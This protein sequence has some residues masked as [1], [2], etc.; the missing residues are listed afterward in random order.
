MQE[1]IMNYFKDFNDILS[2]VI[3]TN[4]KNEGFNLNEGIENAIDLIMTQTAEENKVVFV[5]NGGSA[6]IS[7]HMA[8]DFWKNGEMK[9]LSFN[10]PAQLTCLSNDYG[11]QYVFEKPIRMFADEGDILVAVSSSGRSENILKAVSA[12]RDKKCKVITMSGFNPDNP[13]R[14]SGDLNF[15]VPSTSYG[16]VEVIHQVLCHCILDMIIEKKAEKLVEEAV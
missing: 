10:D 5:G 15:Y 2:N 16:F 4:V 7:S 6:S 1:D 11:Y 8:I 12:S 13:L 9:A 3:V 14:A